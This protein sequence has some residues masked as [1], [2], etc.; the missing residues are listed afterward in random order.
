MP[1]LS[2][3]FAKATRELN[4]LPPLHYQLCLLPSRAANA[5]ANVNGGGGGGSSS[6]SSAS[7]PIDLRVN[8][9]AGI[10]DVF[11]ALRTKLEDVAFAGAAAPS[12]P[13]ELLV[14]VHREASMP[15]PSG[16]PWG[17]L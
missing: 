14:A 12:P 9:L 15:R 8:I 17:R 2:R 1:R 6:S 4:C 5:N 13:R 11:D 16:G 3:L 10:A 7:S